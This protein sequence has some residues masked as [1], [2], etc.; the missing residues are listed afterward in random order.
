LKQIQQVWWARKERQAST[1][2][3]GVVESVQARERVVAA[4]IVVCDDS[5][6]AAN[7]ASARPTEHHD[8]CENFPFQKKRNEKKWEINYLSPQLI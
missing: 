7:S 8:T 4:A 6:I 5:P 2:E 3:T 1:A